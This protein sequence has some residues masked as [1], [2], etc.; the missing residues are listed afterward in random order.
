MSEN[1]TPTEEEKVHAA[2][3]KTIRTLLT[4]GGA[5]SGHL[6]AEVMD[7]LSL[8]QWLH[9]LKRLEEKGLVKTRGHYVV[10]TGPTL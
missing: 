7:V 5:P 3:D 8:E 2:I 10:W 9:L 1:T 6:Y 4:R